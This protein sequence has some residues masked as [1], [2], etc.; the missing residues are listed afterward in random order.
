MMILVRGVAS[1]ICVCVCS[2]VLLKRRSGD[3]KHFEETVKV[4]RRLKE[5]AQWIK[6]NK[7]IG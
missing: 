5:A 7:P 1:P 6:L 4:Y 2:S 3:H